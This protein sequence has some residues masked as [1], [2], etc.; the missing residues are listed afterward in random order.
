MMLLA[1]FLTVYP[2]QT[3]SCQFLDFDQSKESA[4]QCAICTYLCPN[5]THFGGVVVLNCG[6]LMELTVGV[7]S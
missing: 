2:D 7:R 5:A 4:L 1:D 6:L 3:Q